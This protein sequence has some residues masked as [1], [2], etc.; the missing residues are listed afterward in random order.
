MKKFVTEHTKW[1]RASDNSQVRWDEK[2]NVTRC[3]ECGALTVERES[4]EKVKMA[5][6]LQE[7]PVPVVELPEIHAPEIED[8][9]HSA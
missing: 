9:G 7:V 5:D 3:A 4:N 6:V 8:D 2:T 1:C